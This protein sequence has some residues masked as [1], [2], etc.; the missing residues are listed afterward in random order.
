MIN[1]FRWNARE[2]RVRG[3]LSVVPLKRM[4]V[5]GQGSI[6][7]MLVMTTGYTLPL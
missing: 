6:V 7:R 5:R 3:E 2:L 4:T 1:E